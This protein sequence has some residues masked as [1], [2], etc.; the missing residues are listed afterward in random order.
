M[1]SHTGERLL[2]TQQFD[3]NNPELSEAYSVIGREFALIEGNQLDTK[4]KQG[5]RV[6]YRS[7]REIVEQKQA[8][9]GK[10]NNTWFFGKGIVNTLEIQ[11]SPHSKS[12]P[13]SIKH[14]I[15]KFKLTKVKPKLWNWGGTKLRLD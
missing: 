1:V 2:R 5:T 9:L 3:Y 13:K 10:H 14:S 6:L 8:R 11:P 15:P 12:R 4:K 7:R